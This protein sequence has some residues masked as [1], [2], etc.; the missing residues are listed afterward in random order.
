MTR[1]LI[2]DTETTGTI[3][4]YG[5]DYPFIIQLSYALYDTDANKLIETFDAYVSPPESVII[6]P[7]ITNLTGIDRALLKEQGQ[8]ITEVLTKFRRA[9]DMA[10]VV[11][12]HNVDFDIKMVLLE[13]ALHM[14]SFAELIQSGTKE[15][16]CTMKRGTE[17]CKIPNPRRNDFKYPNARKSEFKYPKLVELHEFLFGTV[18]TGLHNS[19]VDVLACLRCYMKM[20][21]NQILP[22]I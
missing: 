10:D 15:I 12:G 3:P 21:H 17:I 9:Y 8:D 19:M 6:T 13:S 22:E 5:T 2:F 7:F 11:V 1:I 16:Y 20:E 4:K 18:P 14:L